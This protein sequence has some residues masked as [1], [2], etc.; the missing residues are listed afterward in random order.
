MTES[1]H[2]GHGGTLFLVATP[3]GNLED[4]TTR[5]L[6]VLREVDLVAAEDTR[7]TRRLLDHF[8]ISATLVSLFEHNE[9]SR[10]SGIVARLN[11][12]QSVAV[13]TDAGSP[14]IADP[15]FPLVRAAVAEGLRVE[16]IPGPS[17]VLAALQV[18]GL[19]TDAFTFVGFLPVKHGAR[20]RLLEEYSDRRETIVAF[21]SP[22]R[23]ERCLED[24]EAVWQERPIA[25]CRELTKLHEQVLRGSASEVKAALRDDQK[26]GEMVLVL[27]G[28]T[29]ASRADR[30]TEA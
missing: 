26:R 18:S 7:R 3:I 1:R 2:S 15:G 5:A 16:S 6:R 22:H 27:G 20:R 19:P 9:R 30:A 23:I 21:E 17:A 29:R 10:I 4:V 25:L 12:G 8:G 11:E 24:L 14:G 28:R 13:V